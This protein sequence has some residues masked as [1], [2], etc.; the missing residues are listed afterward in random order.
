MAGPANEVHGE[1]K[2]GAGETCRILA[3]SSHG[4]MSG[5]GEWAQEPEYEAW[6]PDVIQRQN[7]RLRN[8][9]HAT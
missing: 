5:P 3:E 7:Q 1:S 9:C 6:N 2:V 4:L 8:R